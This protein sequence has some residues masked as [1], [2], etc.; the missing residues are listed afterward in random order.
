M[1]MTGGT[2]RLVKTTYPFS[3]K[4]KAVNLYVYYKSTQDVANN[5]ST[6]YCGMYVTTPSG[7]DIGSWTDFNGSYVGTTSNTF[8]GTIP[9][10]SGTR[11]LV[12]NKTFTVNHSADGKGSAAIY[13]KWGVN[14]PWGSYVNPSGS[15]TIDLPQIPRATTPTLSA[16][17][18][19]M[20]GN[21]TISMPRAASA[22]THTLKYTI[23]GAT[24][25]IASGLGTSYTWTTPKI[26]VQHIPNL[27]KATITITCETYSGSTY[28]GSKTASFTA[29][30]PNTS[31]PTLSASSVQM[32][33]EVTITTNREVSYYTHTLKYTL[34]GTTKEIAT[35]VGA[36]K[37]WTV[38]DLVSLIPNATS[39]KATIT[40]ITYNGTAVVGTKAVAL[41]IKAFDPSTMSF[42]KD[43]VEMGTAIAI[44]ITRDSSKYTHTLK[45][46]IGDTAA[47]I[48][49]GVT[50]T[51]AFAIPKSL[52]SEIPNAKKG[53]ITVKCETYNGTA[54]V[55]TTTK[56][57]TATAPSASVP[58]VNPDP[59]VMGESVKITFNRKVSQ[60]T[61]SLR[62]NLGDSVD[63]V[64]KVEGDSMT[65]T[66]PLG[67][68]RQIPNDTTGE[69]TLML[70]TYNGTANI[71][72]EEITFEVAVPDN[73]V[74]KPKFTTVLSPV[75]SLQS[76]FSEL[77]IQGKSRVNV[78]FAAE[79]E[80]ADIKS[81]SIKIEGN[82]YSGNPSESAVINGSGSIACETTV[83]D[84]RG[85]SRT[86]IQQIPVIAYSKPKIA[87]YN[88][89]SLIV[90]T[91]SL[92]DG[93]VSPRGEYVLIKTSASYSKV[94]SN[95][96]QYN[97]CR[98]W[99]R[100]KLS[101]SADYGVDWALLQGTEVNEVLPEVFSN[102]S[103]YTLQL[104]IED[105]IGEDKVSTYPIP[106]LS[107][108]VHMG[109]GGKNLGLGMFCDYSHED[110]IDVGWTTYFH[111]GIAKKLIFEYGSGV[112]EGQ[113]VNDVSSRTDTTSFM[114]FS[115]FIAVVKNNYGIFPVLC[116]RQGNIIYG[117]V[118][119]IVTDTTIRTCAVSM[120]YS[121]A[122]DTLT[123]TKSKYIDHASNSNHGAIGTATSQGVTALYALI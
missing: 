95:D 101:S 39:G 99:Y 123:V 120:T 91:R 71:G 33:K 73:D 93:T 36:S 21:I 121:V 116:I 38:P 80:Y 96:F 70:T 105:D 97:E 56:K 111:T 59:A 72:T 87:P 66:I 2:S 8:N 31:V 63:V 12:E 112:K 43:T 74:T 24:G 35:M 118:D 7:W 9:N 92:S 88:G 114:S 25:T 42:P 17:T 55:G 122:D 50:T 30:V 117:S 58:T 28:V 84:S 82:S 20:G 64:G 34:G 76:K 10:F 113:I 13:W 68:A 37:A 65:Y 27:L 18:V 14:S 77:Y 54:L 104:M 51:C 98:I 90:C 26:L 6:I 115:L 45:Y 32:G 23:N 5:K 4:T 57:L 103:S 40:C 52:V 48:K 109:E 85:Y 75:H 61:H 81:Y 108:P 47:T 78:T 19:Q 86:I 29:T 53:T 49:S 67:F 60:Y 83:T 16:T 62:F 69:M 22:F 79:S 89:E 119:S 11:W 15:F 94:V 1:A 41:T 100:Y 106:Y 102:K 44:S 3:D 110:A 46:E 107:I